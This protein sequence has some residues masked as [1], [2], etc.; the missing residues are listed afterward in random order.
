MVPA[1]LS[2]SDRSQETEDHITTRSN[3]RLYPPPL[4]SRQGISQIYKYVSAKARCKSAD[5]IHIISFKANS[6]SII[7]TTVDEET[8]EEKKRMINKMRWKGSGPA[9]ILFSDKSV[10]LDP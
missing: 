2:V 10:S 7:T 4:F 9:S 6:A 3:L 8:G 1:D 5:I